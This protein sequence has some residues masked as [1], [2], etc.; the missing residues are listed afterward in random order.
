MNEPIQSLSSKCLCLILSNKKKYNEEQL[1]IMYN[2]LKNKYARV[3][4]REYLCIRQE[5]F[6]NWYPNVYK[7]FSY[8]NIYYLHICTN[9]KICSC[10]FIIEKKYEENHQLYWISKCSY[11]CI[12][13]KNISL[14]IFNNN[15]SKIFNNK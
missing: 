8:N 14:N 1:S 3:Y 9:S 13:D 7:N 11:N 15:S 4:Y 6:G 12:L 5:C 2:I 10:K